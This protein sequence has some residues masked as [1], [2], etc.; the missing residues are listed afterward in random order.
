MRV[1]TDRQPG[2]TAVAPRC[3][4][5]FRLASVPG[6]GDPARAIRHLIR[7][8]RVGGGSSPGILARWI[9]RATVVQVGRRC[10]AV[11]RD[12]RPGSSAG[13]SSAA[14]GGT[15]QPTR[16]VACLDRA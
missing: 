16:L 13:W 2:S 8:G 4:R 5:A 1:A 11:K 14:E 6:G 12:G 15:A 9:A 7:R 3:L 10:R